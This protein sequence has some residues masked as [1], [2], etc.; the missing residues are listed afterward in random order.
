MEVSALLATVRDQFPDWTQM[1]FRVD[2]S[3]RPTGVGNGAREN[4]H[5][6][7]ES[8]FRSRD[9]RDANPTSARSEGL[10]SREGQGGVPAFAVTIKEAG[11]SPRF[12]SR[13]VTMDPYLGTLLKSEE[14]AQLAAGR[15]LRMW[16]RFLHT[17]EALGPAGQVIAGAASL[18]GGILVWT[19]FALAYRRLFQRSN[20]RMNG[21]GSESEPSTPPDVRSPSLAERE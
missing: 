17:G 8:G 16:T 3:Q 7:G 13:Q 20:R 12:A 19:G 2:G 11:A 6:S 4:G 18:G 15:R 9:A 1:T 14:Y 5:S 10:S 21:S